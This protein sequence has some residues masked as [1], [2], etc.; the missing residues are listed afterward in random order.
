MRTI[1]GKSYYIIIG[2]I[3]VSL[4]ALAGRSLSDVFYSNKYYYYDHGILNAMTL[5]DGARADSIF[6]VP[7]A[8]LFPKSEDEIQAYIDRREAMVSLINNLGCFPSVAQAE[9]SGLDNDYRQWLYID[10]S[11][12]SENT[13]VSS[14]KVCDVTDNQVKFMIRAYSKKG[15]LEIYIELADGTI[16]R[17]APGFKNGTQYLYQW[18]RAITGRA[19]QQGI[20]RIYAKS[21]GGGKSSFRLNLTILG[22]N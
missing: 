12:G 7:D 5:M 9:A 19:F 21:G 22:S 14:I 18:E 20:N 1:L 11:V 17:S 6:E 13:E 15:D 3:F 8:P 2:I 4:S 16:H 10:A